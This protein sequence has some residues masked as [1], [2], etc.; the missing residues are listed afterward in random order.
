[1]Y[2]YIHESMCRVL[3]RN[4]LRHSWWA[5][6]GWSLCVH[7]KEIRLQKAW[8]AAMLKGPRE[9]TDIVC[10]HTSNT[11]QGTMHVHVQKG[12]HMLVCTGVGI[13]TTTTRVGMFI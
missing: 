3:P 6:F 5:W 13:V 10:T 9:N 4:I 1:M 8:G 2:M 12:T 11:V 7:V